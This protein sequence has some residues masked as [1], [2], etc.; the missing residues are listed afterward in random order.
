MSSFWIKGWSFEI[1]ILIDQSILSL[2]V[3]EPLESSFVD[4]IQVLLHTGLLTCICMVWISLNVCVVAVGDS[5]QSMCFYTL[6]LAACTCFYSFCIMKHAPPAL[7][8]DAVYVSASVWSACV[9]VC[10]YV[11]ERE[12]KCGGVLKKVLW[13]A[14]CG[15]PLPVRLEAKITRSPLIR[16]RFE[17]CI[18][19]LLVCARGCVCCDTS[20][21]TETTSASYWMTFQFFRRRADLCCLTDCEW[22]H[23]L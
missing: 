17:T 20:G 12:G 3:N 16:Q 15:R 21:Q 5:V 19:K 6:S 2:T 4:Q 22:A 23:A 1:S 10:M 18:C 11:W 8:L 14:P 13:C 7:L 9:Y